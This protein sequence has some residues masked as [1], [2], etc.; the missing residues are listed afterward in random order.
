[1][2]ESM[3]FYLEQPKYTFVLKRIYGMM[4]TDSK[5]LILKKIKYAKQSA[6]VVYKICVLVIK[7]LQ[8]YPFSRVN[9][10]IV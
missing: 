10:I 7:G 2:A 8:E 4:N 3:R 9:I 1:M 5:S 6:G